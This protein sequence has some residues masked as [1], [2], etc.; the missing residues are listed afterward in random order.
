MSMAAKNFYGRVQNEIWT[1]FQREGVVV[2]GWYIRSRDQA[3]KKIEMA[4]KASASQNNG[5]DVF[6][7]FSEEMS[8]VI[9]RAD[10]ISGFSNYLPTRGDIIELPTEFGRQRFEVVTPQGRSRPYFELTHGTRGLLEVFG[11]LCSPDESGERNDE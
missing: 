2:Q 7:V 8:F 9:P 11:I 4:L 3:K 10:L 5:D 6:S 1:A